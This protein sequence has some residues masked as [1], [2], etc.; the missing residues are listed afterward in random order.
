MIGYPM[1]SSPGILFLNLILTQGE[2][3]IAGHA[4]TDSYQDYQSMHAV[5]LSILIA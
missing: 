1:I 5:N 2:T 3:T 4:L